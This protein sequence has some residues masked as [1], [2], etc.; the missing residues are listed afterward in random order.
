MTPLVDNAASMKEAL[1]R[2]ENSMV[3][4]SEQMPIRMSGLERAFPVER[5]SLQEEINCNR[6]E[7]KG[8]KNV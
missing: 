5:E 6:Q 4:Q 2:I 7:V 8:A 1:T 3:E